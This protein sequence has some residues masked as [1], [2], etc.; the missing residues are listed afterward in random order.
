MANKIKSNIQFG[1]SFVNIS[2]VFIIVIAINVIANSLYFRLDI[3]E[4]SLYT[5]S[6]GSKKIVNNINTPITLKY[7]FT[8]GAETLPLNYKVYGNK[9]LELLQEYENQ[10]PGN[11]TLEI[12]DPKPDSDEEEWAQK[13]GLNGVPLSYGE[14]LFMGM[15]AVK[16][17]VELNIPIFDPKREQFMEYDISELL[18]NINKEQNKVIG[19]LSGLPVMG[20]S[21]NQMQA[22]QGQQATPKWIFLQELE[23]SYK[24]QNIETSAQEISHD[25]DILLVIHPKN[26][27]EAT[28]Y[29]IEQFALKGGQL[30]VLVDPNSQMDQ[31]AAMMARMGQ[32]ASASSDLPKLFKHWGVEYQ[33]T[34]IMGDHAHATEVSSR[35]AGV[36]PFVLWQSLNKSSFNQDLIAT[37]DLE[38]M[39][40]VEPGGFTLK[41]DS[42]LKLNSLL[43]SSTQSGLVDS[44]ILRYTNPLEVNKQ[45]K[46]EGAY[47]IAG[48]LTGKISS[49]FSKRPDPPKKEEKQ[50]EEKEET[51]KVFQPHVSES[52][53]NVKVL[54]I[55]DTDFIADRNSVRQNSLFGVIPMNDNLNFMINMVEF[56]SGS[57][58]LTQI[59]SRGQFSRPFSRF[60]ELQQMAQAKYQTEEQK[61]SQKLQSVQEKLSALNVQKGTNKIVLTKDQIDKIKQFRLAEKDAQRK[62]REIRKLLRQDI[63]SEKTFLILLNLLFVPILLA[64]FG[65]FL[66]LK[67]FNRSALHQ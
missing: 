23:K 13:Y 32:M 56:L 24:L 50:G 10:N 48:I 39:L 54:L 15:V 67:R 40:I 51:P 36:F 44:F 4:N 49:A 46:R 35:D 11:I 64:V 12:Y 57:E 5:L 63:E 20:Q 18:L 55:T 26:L 21:P 30:V 59:R 16:E 41:E 34:K 7:Y 65:I 25:I 19:I 9:V 14:T 45:V 22:M 66:Y 62:L 27:S 58:E 61:L 2:L 38:K 8:K 43:K 28:E 33:S 1:S 29:A 47:N 3:T 42:K 52:K 60:I 37:K 31:Q 53:D 6:E 17:D